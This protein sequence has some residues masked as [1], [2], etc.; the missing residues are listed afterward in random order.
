MR[1]VFA[2]IVSLFLASTASAQSINFFDQL[3]L[4]ISPDF[5]A[6]NTTITA[7]VQ[8][9][10]L[11]LDRSLLTW[12]VD[13]EIVAEGGGLTETTVAL[14]D[15]GSATRILVVAES[16]SGTNVEVERVI[17]PTE[18]DLIWEA[19]S[20]VPPFYQGKRLVSS[21][22]RIRT[23]ALPRLVRSNGTTVPARDIV[24]TWKKNGAI[25]SSVSGRGKSIATF[26]A[27]LLFGRDTISVEA[28]SLDGTLTAE[29]SVSVSSADPTIV[30]YQK[31]PLFGTMYHQALDR[32]AYITDVEA[33]FVAVP[34]FAPARISTDRALAYQWRVNNNAIE[35]DQ[36]NPDEITINAGNSSGA[37]RV[38][39]AIAHA[40]DI[41]FD[42]RNNWNLLL[43]SGFGG[44]AQNE[45]DAGFFGTQQ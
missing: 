20:Y 45:F 15:L 35:T 13:G 39:L 2:F 30:L 38:E 42:A 11:D 10:S 43:N 40:T 3:T 8:S 44:G 33:T 28:S 21:S 1:I 9:D 29:T 12:Y 7:R 17:R 27:P 36:T 16:L 5:P 31:H 25:V 18:I 41:F 32:D 26:P 19:D 6:A 37:A 24:Y 14:G 34:Y 22:S 23:Q 4:S